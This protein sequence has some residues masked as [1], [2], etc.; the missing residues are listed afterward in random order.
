MTICETA[1]AP[2]TGATAQ[3]QLLR[4]LRPIAIDVGLPLGSYYLLR[5]A[6]G[7]SIWMALTLSSIGPAARTCY[8]MLAEHAINTLAALM[9]AVNVAGIVVSLITGDPRDMIAKDSL[10]SSVFAIAIL[11]SVLAHRPLMSAGLKPYVTRGA[12]DRT[13]AWD[14]MAATSPR[15]RRFESL[16]SSIWGAALLGEC[17]AR[18]IGAYMLPVATM[19][20]LG[21]VMTLGAIGLAICLGGVAVAPIERMIRAET[22][23]S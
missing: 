7:V 10:V 1:R 12:P 11:A 6:L 17:V 23:T 21:G 16:Y 14:R 19:V 3:A 8:A 18:L 20:W 2:A 9:L 15:F 5:D 13:A 4:A 22:R